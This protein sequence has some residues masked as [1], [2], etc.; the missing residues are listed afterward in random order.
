MRLVRDRRRNGTGISGRRVIDVFALCDVS[1]RQR[2]E[3][4][5]AAE[6]RGGDV[7]STRLTWM[8]NGAFASSLRAT[9]PRPSTS[10]RG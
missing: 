9:S 7:S 1:I 10:E 5:A 2:S 8:H 6:R 4:R 3:M